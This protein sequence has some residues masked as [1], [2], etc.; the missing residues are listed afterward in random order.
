MS[1]EP[2]ATPPVPTQQA[3]ALDRTRIAH[4][5][6]LMARIRTS[7]SMISFGFTIAEVFEYLGESTGG[8]VITVAGPRTAGLGLIGLGTF[9]L[10]AAS[11]QHAVS[12]RHL[13]EPGMRTPTSLA[14][15]I[16]VLMSIGG[17]VMFCTVVL[18]PLRF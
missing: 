3:L 7:M 10:I 6:T 4:E 8:G 12:L 17:V 2:G 1:V 13:V 5:R 16:A 11:L 18:N 14:L 9:A 15:V